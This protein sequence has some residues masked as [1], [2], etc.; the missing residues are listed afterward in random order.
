M[1]VVKPMAV[2]FSFRPFVVGG[3]Q[4]LSVSSLI[5]FSLGEGVR[6]LVSEIK[7]WPAVGEVIQ[8]VVDEGL[9][10][11]SGEVLAYG[12]CF[13]GATM[14]RPRRV[15]DRQPSA[16]ARRQDACD[17]RRSLLV[18]HRGSERVDGERLGIPQG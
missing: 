9:P 16:C 6:R 2:S 18:G 7:L 4:Q 1:K 12:S 14:G 15:T 13:A 10:K 5:G 8:G 3:R 11:P 17:L